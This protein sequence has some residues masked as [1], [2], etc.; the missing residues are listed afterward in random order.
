VDV[1][2]DKDIPEL[3]A[4]VDGAFSLPAPP[5]LPP[6]RPPV[7]KL[8]ALFSSPFRG[9]E[10]VREKGKKSSGGLCLKGALVMVVFLVLVIVTVE[11]VWML[12]EEGGERWKYAWARVMEEWVG[13]KRQEL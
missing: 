13:G 4:E 6:S 10:E 3:I 8:G 5:S 1:I 7:S 12:W 9:A 11:L 2:L